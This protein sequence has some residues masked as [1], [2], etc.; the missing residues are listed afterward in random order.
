MTWWAVLLLVCAAVIA[1]WAAFV[2]A[3]YVSGRH[4]EARAL[5]GFIPDCLQLVRGLLGDS[6]LRRRDKALLVALLGYLALPFDLVPDFIPVAGQLDDV[7]VVGWVLRRL[8]R[9]AGPEIV[10]EHWRG[11][12]Q[13]LRLILRLAG[14]TGRG[15]DPGNAATEAADDPVQPRQLVVTTDQWQV[16]NPLE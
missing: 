13:S 5:A 16:R 14:V 3:L 15:V 10:R 7:L 2:G 11:P 6:R 12:D 9:G 1:L 4:G 8:V